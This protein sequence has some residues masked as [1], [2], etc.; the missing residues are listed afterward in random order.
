MTVGTAQVLRAVLDEGS[1]RPWGAAEQCAVTS[2]RYAAELA[3]A[4]AR[5]GHDESVVVGEG[6]LDG[7]RVAVAVGDF[8]FLGGSVGVAAAQLLIACTRRATDEGLPLL[9]AP[10]S[11]G[12]RMQEGT[13]AFVQMAAV[14]AALAEHRRRGLPYLVWLRNPT[15]GGVFASWGSLGQVVVA[16]PGAAIGF[17]GPRVYEGLRGHPFPEGVQTAENLVAHG[18]LDAVVP[19]EQLRSAA[20]ATL[21]VLAAPR[22]GFLPATPARPPEPGAE[23]S[24][25]ECVVRTRGAGRPGVREVLRLAGVSLV[26]LSG[27]G[28]GEVGPSTVLGL[29]CIGPIPCVLVGQDRNA[30]NPDHPLGPADLRVARRGIALAGEL[31]LA[32]VT[33][34]DTP[35]ADL[36][37]A[38]EQGALAAEIAGCLRDL[39][40]TA[41]P[42]V[43]VLLGQ[44]TGGAALALA[45]TDRVVAA[46]HAWL[47]PLP[48]EG[49][50]VIVHRTVERAAD[51]ADAQG[52]SSTE[53]LRAGI[54]DRLVA[55]C[56]DA[57]DEPAAF[58][59]R[60][61]LA[62][63]DELA[64][65]LRSDPDER[66]RLRLSA[67]GTG[68]RLAR[69]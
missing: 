15:F 18:V 12:T 56:P 23:V 35:G 6:R 17:L 41:V 9:A 67:R 44:G 36:S 55:E 60:L 63:E 8:A 19:L 45:S 16:E 59:Q 68:D 52:V 24:G 39:A 33:L 13:A 64:G 20:A 40:G 54:V 32:L 26:E 43:G 61:L 11:G 10:V 34:V 65:L 30:Q 7:R 47:S 14:A 37:P 50:S 57:A 3:A 51:M 69:A 48:P 62:V 2:E 58:A 31:G 21:A 38:A 1:F 5:S 22:S 49:A 46:Q 25:W 28:R 42:T 53:L 27:T 4:R 29:A 66:R